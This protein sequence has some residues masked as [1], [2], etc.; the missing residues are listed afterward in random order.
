M[1]PKK[2]SLGLRAFDAIVPELKESANVEADNR[3]DSLD[4]ITVCIKTKWR[5]GEKTS[6]DAT[7][8]DEVMLMQ[9]RKIF[10][11]QVA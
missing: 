4:L 7:V 3:L 8:E 11:E 5:A 6:V 2:A 1:T 10:L 9:C